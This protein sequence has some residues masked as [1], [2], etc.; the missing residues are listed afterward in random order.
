[1]GKTY[2]ISDTHFGHRNI[3]RHC[4]RPFDDADQMDAAMIAAWN[5]VVQPEDTVY[6]LGDFSLR[7]VPVVDHLLSRLHGTKH[8]IIGNHDQ[9]HGVQGW[10]SIRN[11]DQITVD[12]HH[13]FLCHYPMREWPGMWHGTIHLYGH[14]HG[15]M[16]SLPGSMDVG[17]DVWGGSPVQLAEMLPFIDRFDPNKEHRSHVT[18]RDWE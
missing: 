6:H 2:F 13:L 7:P 4:Q 9:A 8:L 10:K 16:L 12:G 5:R 1:M 3:I 15:N 14:V 11:M 17:A 18:W